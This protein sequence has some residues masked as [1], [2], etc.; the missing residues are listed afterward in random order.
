V[1]NPNIDPVT[2][3]MPLGFYDGW[4]N[5]LFR[6][7]VWAANMLNSGYYAWRYN[8]ATSWVLSD[9][10][11]VPIDP[12][13][14]AGTAG[15]QYTFAQLDDYGTW[16][17]DVSPGGFYDTYYMLF[18]NSFDYAV[19]PLIPS[20]LVQ[21]ELWLPFNAGEV[22]AFTGGP[23]ASWD[24]GTP[25]GA[26]DFAPPG[27]ALGC[28]PDDHWITAVADG[29]VVRTGDGA[30]ALDL[31]LDGLEQTG[32]VIVYMHIEQRERVLPGTFLRA[33]DPLGHASCEGGVSSG[34]HVHITRKFNGE[35]IPVM[36]ATPFTMS[37]WLAAG[38]GEEYVGSLSRD[39]RVVESY[40]GNSSINQVSR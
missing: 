18:G 7:M 30:V 34:T 26:L 9:G 23:H 22:W 6:Q 24:S 16:L 19:E 40:E 4:Y 20:P 11:V 25:Y 5:G 15:V 1:T 37:G 8:L 2:I 21:P 28:V 33:G 32:W 3:E 13:L 29:L 38:T 31:D 36:G 39:G 27:E 35:W 17:L 10:S 14:N 12:T